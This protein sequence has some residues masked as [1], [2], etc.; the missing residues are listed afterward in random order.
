GSGSEAAPRLR[1]AERGEPSSWRFSIR[2]SL[3]VE[4]SRVQPVGAE[5]IRMRALLHD[6]A[7]VEHDDR[8]GI[9]YRAEP[10]RDEH[11][12]P[13]TSGARQLPVDVG[14]GLG[15]QTGTRLIQDE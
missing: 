6:L 10:M 7:R 5:Q 4:Q 2:R 13:V 11:A 8:V 14:L 12:G 9:P 1:P 15:V 3:E